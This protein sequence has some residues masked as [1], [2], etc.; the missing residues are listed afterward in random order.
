VTHPSLPPIAGRE[1]EILALMQQPSPQPVGH[2][3]GPAGE[4]DEA[5]PA[6]QLPPLAEGLRQ[7]ATERLQSIRS[8]FACALH[9]HQPTIPAGV[10]GALI[11]HLQWMLEHQGVGENHN[12]AAFAHCYRRLADLL[13]A[14]LTIPSHHHPCWCQVF[15]V[16]GTMDVQAE[17]EEAHTIAAGGYYF[18]E[19]GDTHRETAIEDS[20]LLVICED[21]RPQPRSASR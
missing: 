6:L 5:P 2:R 13:P 20:L 21:D 1:A 8:A 18:V 3:Q 7:G 19:P 16:Q 11:S 12:A 17:G 9:R 15:V 14:G 4:R 10:D